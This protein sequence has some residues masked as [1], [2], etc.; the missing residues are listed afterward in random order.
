VS[1]IKEIVPITRT[2]DEHI[3]DFDEIGMVQLKEHNGRS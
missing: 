2:I 1:L 3:D